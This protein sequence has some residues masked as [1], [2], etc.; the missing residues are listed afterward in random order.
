MY[1]HVS[2]N[3]PVNSQAIPAGGGGMMSTPWKV[4]PFALIVCGYTVET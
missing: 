1:W 4:N 2:M 3:C